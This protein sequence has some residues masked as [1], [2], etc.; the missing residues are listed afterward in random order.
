MWKKRV[1]SILLMLAVVCSCA[2]ATVSAAEPTANK[3][4]ILTPQAT[5]RFQMTVYANRISRSDSALPMSAGETV[6]ITASYT[7]RDATVHFGLIDEEGTFHFVI[8]NGGTMD[9]TIRIRENGNYVLAVRNTADV[10]IDVSGHV[11]Y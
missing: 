8:A 1:V 11:T 2:V 5:G 7:P 6:Q 9:R 4:P 10:D 3:P